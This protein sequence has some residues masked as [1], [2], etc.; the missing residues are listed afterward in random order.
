MTIVVAA[1]VITSAL[2]VSAASNE[3]YVSN[4]DGATYSA[5]R[6][7]QVEAAFEEGL[8]TELQKELILTHIEEVVASESYG[9][10]PS[11]G[12]KGDGNV[13]CVLGEDSEL[14]IFRSESAGQRTGEGNGVGAKSQDGTGDGEGT[15]ARNGSGE[16]NGNNSGG[17]LGSRNG[18]GNGTGNGQGK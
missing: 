7:E 12:S 8:I 2:S 15:S 3:N 10:G 18:S 11:N 14:G 4:M 1:M 13:V 6:V 16:G 9:D 5:T 17:S